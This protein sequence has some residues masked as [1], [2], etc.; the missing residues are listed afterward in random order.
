VEFFE[1]FDKEEAVKQGSERGFA[2]VFAVFFTLVG[3]VKLYLGVAFW[4]VWFLAATA[5]L[6]IGLTIPRLLY[7]PNRLWTGFGLLLSRVIQPVVLAL[8]FF[9]AIMPTGLLMR[10]FGKD[11]LTRR[12]EP[13]SNSYWIERP[14]GTDNSMTNQF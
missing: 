4:W 12:F 8:L 3:T 1:R 14:S 7:W 10:L 6:A 13:E 9:L 2:I 11:P 5:T